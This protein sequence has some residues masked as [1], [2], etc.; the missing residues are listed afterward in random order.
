[1]GDSTEKL[2]A[3][4]E[5]DRIL[6]TFADRGV[7]AAVVGQTS[8]GVEIE[9]KEELQLPEDTEMEIETGSVWIEYHPPINEEYPILI[10]PDG[11]DRDATVEDIRILEG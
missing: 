4:R 5:N 3:L 6:I 10:G 8:K 2:E 1:M 11:T 7:E 9:L